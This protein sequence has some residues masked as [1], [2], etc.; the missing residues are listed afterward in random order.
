MDITKAGLGFS[1]DLH[2]HMLAYIDPGSGAMLLQFI[3][4]AVVGCVAYFRKAIFG[5]FRKKESKPVVS[6]KTPEEGSS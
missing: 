2:K 6:A 1:T 3:I 4:A 5:L